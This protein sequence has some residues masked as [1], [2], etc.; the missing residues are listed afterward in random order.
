MPDGS[1][2]RKGPGCRLH[3]PAGKS[4]V[5]NDVSKQLDKARKA[6]E[7]K[8]KKLPFP[9]GNKR[10]GLNTSNPDW[11]ESL[12][13]KSIKLEDEIKY[14]YL[15]TVSWYRSGGSKQINSLLRTGREGHAQAVQYEYGGNAKDESI[16]NAYEATE[17]HIKQ[18][19]EGFK[20]AVTFDEPVLVYRSSI[21]YRDIPE[22]M[23]PLEYAKN[24]YTPGKEI[25]EHSYVSTSA[26]PDCMTLYGRKRI[27]A[28]GK[29]I[30][31]EI[32]VKKG[33]PV[34]PEKS[35]SD[36]HPTRPSPGDIQSYEREI[37]LDRGTKFRV[38]GVKNVT[39]KSSHGNNRYSWDTPDSVTFPVVQ[40]EQIV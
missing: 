38:I 15:G 19:D 9:E 10:V 30:V 20:H 29:N 28:K 21:I 26:D 32:A 35:K 31:F 39:F 22:G 18:I 1:I 12:Y 17:R 24:K 23:T 14:P 37:L 11:A 6:V 40:L 4:T 13:E 3:D 36:P 5:S 27:K 8:D 25:I 34:L 33:L 16:K 2:C 7:A